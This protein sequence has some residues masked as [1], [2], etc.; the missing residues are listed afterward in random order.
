MFVMILSVSVIH[1]LRAICNSVSWNLP[2]TSPE[3][4]VCTACGVT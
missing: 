1:E 3:P 2:H 4:A